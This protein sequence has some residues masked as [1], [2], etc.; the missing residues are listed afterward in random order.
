MLFYCKIEQV[1]ARMSIIAGSMVENITPS[2]DA[3]QLYI[4]KAHMRSRWAT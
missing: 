3:L 4:K 1:G 2:L